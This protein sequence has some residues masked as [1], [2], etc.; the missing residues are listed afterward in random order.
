MIG[1]FV[2]RQAFGK[3][4][5]LRTWPAAWARRVTNHGMHHVPE[6]ADQGGDSQQP[7]R[8]EQQPDFD[9]VIHDHS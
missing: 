1:Q 9:I 5:G 2:P 7:E 4:A 3:A 8:R 6:A